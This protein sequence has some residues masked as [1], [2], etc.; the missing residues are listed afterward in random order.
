LGFS[1]T[2]LLALQENEAWSNGSAEV[3]AATV[4]PVVAEVEQLP[5][6]NL[7]LPEPQPSTSGMPVFIIYVPHIEVN[8][9]D[10]LIGVMTWVVSI[11]W[12]DHACYLSIPM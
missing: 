6:R 2:I 5:A 1:N 12:L 4:I 3:S 11:H 8:D 7:Q 10:P 9:K